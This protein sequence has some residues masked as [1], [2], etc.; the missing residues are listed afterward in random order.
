MCIIILKKIGVEIP[1]K[2]ILKT[3]FN[4]NDDGS[5]FMYVKNN[6]V[7]IDKGYMSLKSLRKSLHKKHFTK[8]DLVVYHFRLATSGNKTAK[9]CHPFPITNNENKLFALNLKTDIGFAHN[10]I[11][12]NIDA[13]KKLSDTMVFIKDILSE[14]TIKSNI[15]N[16]SVFFTLVE[17]ATLSSKLIFLNNKGKY[18]ATGLWIE[19][20]KT[21]LFFSNDT[22]EYSYASIMKWDKY[23]STYQ[24][25]KY[26]HT[27]A[28]YTYDDDV[29]ER[30]TITECPKCFD[31]SYDID[32]LRCYKCGFEATD[33]PACSSGY[34]SLQD[35]ECYYCGYTGVTAIMLPRN[36]D[37]LEQ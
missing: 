16:D 11:F 25:T 15:F 7:I 21:G 35:K 14:K 30:D 33:C 3:C 6:H 13:T 12:S 28:K 10:G 24:G 34:Y 22:Y 29:T 36:S 1:T 31:D 17:K 37:Y 18:K 2:K 23:N 4:N 8:D 5:G 26:N 32:T 20:K 27:T 9:Q 19:D